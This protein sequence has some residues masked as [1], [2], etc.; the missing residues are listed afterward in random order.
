MKD[1]L[2]NYLVANG[3][4]RTAEEYSAFCQRAKRC[5]GEE[6]V[7][8]SNLTSRVFANID[9]K[10]AM[11]KK[12][13]SDMMDKRNLYVE[14]C[15]MDSRLR[16]LVDY[17]FARELFSPDPTVAE[18]ARNAIERYSKCNKGPGGAVVIMRSEDEMY[19]GYRF[20]IIN[21]LCFTANRFAIGFR[22]DG[23]PVRETM[24]YYKG[25]RP[26]GVRAASNGVEWNL[27]ECDASLS[28]DNF[29]VF[30]NL[31]DGDGTIEICDWINDG[32]QRIVFRRDY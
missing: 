6:S 23:G 25:C 14:S 8:S 12:I 26:L 31:L 21:M 28:D 20:F 9:L 10:K 15:F 29:A 30:S 24:T 19:D 22:T 17:Y 3:D 16:A 32:N 27:I 13:V 1:F 7:Y 2:Y 5:L 11:A 4:T 18:T